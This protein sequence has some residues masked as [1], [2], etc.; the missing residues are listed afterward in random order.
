MPFTQQELYERGGHF[1]LC[2]PGGAIVHVESNCVQGFGDSK[3]PMDG[4]RYE[5]GGK[6]LFPNG[7]R[8]RA[9]LM[10]KAKMPLGLIAKHSYCSIIGTCYGLNEPELPAWLQL[11]I[12]QPFTIRWSV[13]LPLDLEDKGPYECQIRPPKKRKQ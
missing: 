6:I 12:D 9:H 13:D 5:A 4:R 8:L 11:P 1:S 3:I 2:K 10:F 7:Q